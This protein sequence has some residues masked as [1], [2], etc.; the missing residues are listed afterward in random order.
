MHFAR[1]VFLEFILFSLACVCGTWR[2]DVM[3]SD[4]DKEIKTALAFLLEKDRASFKSAKELHAIFGDR[5]RPYSFDRLVER[6]NRMMREWADAVFDTPKLAALYVHDED[7]RMVSNAM[8]RLHRSRARLDE[9]VKDPLPN[10]VAA[11]ARAKR[12]SQTSVNDEDSNDD[13]DDVDTLEPLQKRRRRSRS[14]LGG[15]LIEPKESAVQLAFS[16]EDSDEEEIEEPNDDVEVLPSTGKEPLQ[17][18]NNMSPKKKQAKSQQKPY[19]GKR[20]WTLEEKNAIKEGIKV[21]GRGNWAMIKERFSR[22]LADRT[23]GQIKV[24][25]ECERAAIA[26]NSRIRCPHYFSNEY[27]LLLPLLGL[28]PYNEKAWRTKKHTR[29]RGE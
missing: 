7:K 27:F 24:G 18:R 13:G 6:T 3:A 21:C 25:F 22:I 29:R 15:R 5:K 26:M 19:E 20:N 14:R 11:A 10:V 1:V 12:R 4:E 9:S 2:R 23:S 28:C 17:A 8:E 16:Q